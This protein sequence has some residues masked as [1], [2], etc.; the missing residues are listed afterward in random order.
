M[1]EKIRE[2]IQGPIAIG[3]IVLIGVPL[4]I[5]FGNMDMSSTGQQFAARVNGEEIPRIDFDRAFQNERFAQQE[6]L[7]TEL[8]PAMEEQI[9][10]NV[11][12]QMVLS[13]AVTQFVRDSG[14]RVGDSKVA[15]YI[16]TMPVFQVGGQFSRP[17]YEAALAGQGISPSRFENEQRTF[18]SRQQLQDG[19]IQSAFYTPDEFRRFIELELERREA[20]YV[21]LDAAALAAGTSISEED[22]QAFYA[23]NREQL[24]QSPEQAAI[25]YVE[26]RLADISGDYE[27]D[28]ATLRKAY[29]EAEAGRFRT[30]EE[31]RGRHILLAVTA[32]KDEDA[33]RREAEEVA[34][35]L[36]A[37]GDFAALAAEHSDDP[38]SAGQGGDLGWAGRGVYAPEF[39]AV[40]FDLEPGQVSAPVRTPFGFH[41]IRLDE[42]KA[43]TQR[44][45]EEVRA[46]LADELRR[47]KAQD[48]YYAIAEQ[49]DDLALENPGSLAPVAEATGLPIRRF[50]QFTR[51]GG[52]PFGDNRALVSA[53]FAEEVLE[54][55][56]NTPLVELGEGRAVV[57]RV[58][59]HR[60]PAPLP[61]E[62]VRGQIVERLRNLRAANEARTRGEALL[63]RVQAGESLA[64]AAAAEGLTV[65]G[66]VSLGRQSATLPGELLEAIFRAPKPAE[67]KPVV[68]GL[69]L[70]N[71]YAVFRVDSVQPGQPDSVPREIRDQRKRI[72]AQQSGLKDTELLATAL[73]S[74]A[75]VR[76]APDLFKSAADDL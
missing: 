4:A 6:A 50:E 38:G 3:I 71:G 49:M 48:E 29:E 8:T 60:P 36:A 28:E 37:G 68:Q 9:K 15:E 42:V 39:E 17:S 33:A 32:D 69:P 63:K 66:P 5:T 65:T 53:I 23:T 21:L 73:R 59:E 75:D 18:L 27:P 56:E 57:A 44:S 41:I 2:R 10:R 46:E 22:I 43:G 30:E 14:F 58:V 70:G 62:Q 11:L 16:R 61:L 25:E 45:F 35:K 12:D 19:L 34:A 31:R 1:L 24:F 26:V 51:D 47:R 7:R 13:R 54:G 20:A 40:L 67:G 76:I 55:G 72:L 52:G 74:A 64:D